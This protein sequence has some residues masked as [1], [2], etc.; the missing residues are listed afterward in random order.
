MNAIVE[1]ILNN[2]LPRHCVMCGCSSG[3]DNLCAA[4]ATGLPRVSHACRQCGLPLLLPA[5]LFCSNCLTRSPPWDYAT[6]ALVYRFPVDQLVCQF[7][8]GRNLACGQIL[9]RELVSAVRHNSGA[10]PGCIL[11]VP[12]HRLRHYTRAFNQADILARNLGRE[13]A[14][15]VVGSILRRRRHTRAQSGLDAEARKDNT[16]GAFECRIPAN[17]QAAFHH[18]ALV[19]DVMTTGATLAECTNALKKAGAETISVWVAA[20][21]PQP[22]QLPE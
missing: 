5:D 18:V 21:A 15:P 13:F 9:S 12:L 3:P 7:K 10:L 22:H 11:P 8:F 17:R 16:R 4:C 6:A 20:R 19:D 14:I 2:L 1:A